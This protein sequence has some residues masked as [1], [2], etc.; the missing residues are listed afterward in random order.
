MSFG[1]LNL[2]TNEYFIYVRVI[3]F[4]VSVCSGFLKSSE[5]FGKFLFFPN[6]E[7]C[8]CLL[9][10]ER[11]KNIWSGEIVLWCQRGASFNFF[12]SFFK[13]ILQ[14]YAAWG[15][16]DLL[17][18]I[19]PISPHKR[20]Y[21]PHWVYWYLIATPWFCWTPPAS[22]PNCFATSQTRSTGMG[23]QTDDSPLLKIRT[24]TIEPW[25]V[26]GVRWPS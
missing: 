19:P 5:S 12:S 4:K 11:K 22:L 15:R 3:R 16:P 18:K 23:Q 14:G 7:M 1:Y 17:P 21:Q 6:A 26:T 8:C 9:G 24:P 25:W 13:L 2:N 10:R 20:A